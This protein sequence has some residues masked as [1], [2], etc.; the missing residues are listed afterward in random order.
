MPLTDYQRKPH[1]VWQEQQKTT[2]PNSNLITP[3]E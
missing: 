1:V 2:R 3:A